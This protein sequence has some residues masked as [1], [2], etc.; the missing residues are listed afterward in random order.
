MKDYKEPQKIQGVLRILGVESF[1]TKCEMKEGCY[2][3][4]NERKMEFER[5]KKKKQTKIL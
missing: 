1:S 3:K 2:F 5:K 4:H